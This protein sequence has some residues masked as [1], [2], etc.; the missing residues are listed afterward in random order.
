MLTP[1]QLTL[2]GMPPA[3]R[4]QRPEQFH[5]NT[6][7]VTGQLQRLWLA[8]DTL[9]CR[10]QPDGQSGLLTLNFQSTPGLT[11]SLAPF[12]GRFFRGRGR[13]G[14]TAQL[15]HTIDCPDL[16]VS[17]GACLAKPKYTSG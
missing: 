9:L 4:A 7:Q 5:A 12:K 14:E 6:A 13:S 10:L 11:L 1:V 8:G 16:S 17:E 3:L 2:P 15:R